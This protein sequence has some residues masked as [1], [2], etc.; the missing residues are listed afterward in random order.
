[1]EIEC[2]DVTWLFLVFP[3][4]SKEAEGEEEPISNGGEVLLIASGAYNTERRSIIPTVMHCYVT[5]QAFCNFVEKTFWVPL[6]CTK[7]ACDFMTTVICD[8]HSYTDK[9]IEVIE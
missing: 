7:C 4:P 8:M 9:S 2:R 1:M 6:M 3:A 5:M